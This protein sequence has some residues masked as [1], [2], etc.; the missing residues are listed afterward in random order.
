MSQ[1]CLGLN[2]QTLLS[3][4]KV[5]LTLLLVKIVQRKSQRVNTHYSSQDQQD[6]VA[7]FNQDQQDPVATVNQDQQDPVATVNQDQ[8]DPIA[9]VNQDQQDLVATVSQDQQDPVATVNQDQQ[10]P[11]ATPTQQPPAAQDVV[12]NNQAPDLAQRG[13][14]D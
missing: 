11:V 6:P 1:V 14:Y 10:D 9:T 13:T 2:C 8:Q 3:Q 12:Q 5:Q 7:M 4:R